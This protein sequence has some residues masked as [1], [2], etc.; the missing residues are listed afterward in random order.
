MIELLNP[1]LPG[2]EAS[3]K[4]RPK[5]GG[6]QSSDYEPQH[7]RKWDD[8]VKRAII[9]AQA[10]EAIKQHMAIYAETLPTYQKMREQVIN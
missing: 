2:P 5:S 1:N 6:R 4:D 7:D 3:Y 10:T 8:D 9:M